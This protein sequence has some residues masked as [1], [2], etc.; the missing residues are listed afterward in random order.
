MNSE[1]IKIERL[2]NAAKRARKILGEDYKAPSMTEE[3]KKVRLE[4]AVKRAKEILNTKPLSEE[5]KKLQFKPTT[6]ITA[7]SIVV[8]KVLRQMY[9]SSCRCSCHCRCRR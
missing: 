2:K 5:E 4:N 9:G 8:K 7:D 6:K 3:Q 1:D